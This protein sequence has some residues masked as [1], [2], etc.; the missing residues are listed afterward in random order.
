MGKIGP[1]GV[2]QIYP[3]LDAGEIWYLNPNALNTD[4][5]FNP[6]GTVTGTLTDGYFIEDNKSPVMYIEPSTGYNLR[7][8]DA[9]ISHKE[10]ASKGYM[11]AT[12][13]W[14]SVEVTG[15]FNAISY[16]DNF[17]ISLFARGA[18]QSTP[19]PWCPG[20]NYRLEIRSDGFYRFVK[21]QYFLA[22]SPKDWV[23]VMQLSD[24]ISLQGFFGV[25]LCV[26]N[27]DIGNGKQGV[28]L[29]FYLDPGLTNTFQKI[30]E[31]VDRGAWGAAGAAC[32]GSA[33]QILTWASP[34]VGI[35]LNDTDD[36]R[37]KLLSAR[38][39][40]PG[41]NFPEPVPEPG[42]ILVSTVHAYRIGVAA[43][44]TCESVIPQDPNP[45]PPTPPP[46]TT[47]VVKRLAETHKIKSS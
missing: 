2:F 15:Y 30:G 32:S 6:D 40:N 28:K 47:T 16:G 41:G 3:D 31:I 42:K 35:S 21:Q 11:W 13:D 20:C 26:F 23:D 17:Q 39:I 25:K 38:T 4:G 12:N 14:S 19:M 1:D 43:K 7:S 29:E 10:I 24:P 9:K 44:Q 33:D 18:E 5:R 8:L 27:I 45:P 36:V 34:L 37:F 46:G 22:S